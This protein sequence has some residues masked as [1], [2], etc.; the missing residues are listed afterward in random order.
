MIVLLVTALVGVLS[1]ARLARL[2]THDS[3][4][5]VQAIREWYVNR[6]VGHS[7]WADLATCPFCAAPWLA[8]PI[9]GWAVAVQAWEVDGVWTAEGAW[10]LFN[11]WLAVAYLAAMIV[12]YD[13][14]A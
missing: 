10:W 2:A 14:P 12:A 7:T 3:F 1:V 9:G 8:L 13:E 5:P 4:P 6:S 11:G